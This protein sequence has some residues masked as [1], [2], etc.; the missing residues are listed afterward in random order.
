MTRLRYASLHRGFLRMPGEADE[1]RLAPAAIARRLRQ[2]DMVEISS[3]YGRSAYALSRLAQDYGIG[4]TVSVAPWRMEQIED[5]G[6][7]AQNLYEGRKLIHLDQILAQFCAIAAE[8]GA[9]GYIR[10]QSVLAIDDYRAA[11]QRGQLQNTELPPPCRAASH[12]CMH[13]APTVM[14][15]GA[16]HRQLGTVAGSW[17]LAAAGNYVRTYGEGP[18]KAGDALLH[19]TD[20]DC[21]FTPSD[22]LFLLRR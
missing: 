18:Q 5:Q 1:K 16:G 21:S 19:S 8:A 22:T 10:T 7:S 14:T 3:L 2:G 9:T 17:R 6:P 12:S 4:A 15:C 20:F 11:V 13:S